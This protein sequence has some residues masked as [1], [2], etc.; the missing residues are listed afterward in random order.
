VIFSLIYLYND[1]GKGNQIKFG[2]INPCP[3]DLFVNDN[4]YHI[5]FNIIFISFLLYFIYN[6]SIFIIYYF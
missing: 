4:L 2:K 1:D 5:L 6:I 3:I